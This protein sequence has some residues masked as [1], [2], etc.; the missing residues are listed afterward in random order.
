MEPA[1]TLNFA[2]KSP[3]PFTVHVGSPLVSITNPAAE[4]VI[5]HPLSPVAKPVP[6]M[7]ISVAALSSAFPAP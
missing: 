2:V 5:V 7:V 4:D 1:P 6:V 3:L